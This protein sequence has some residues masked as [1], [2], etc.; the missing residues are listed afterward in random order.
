LNPVMRKI[1]DLSWLSLT[2]LMILLIRQRY[3][4]EAARAEAQ[5]LAQEVEAV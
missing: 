1:F 3:E 2:A 4:L 5:I